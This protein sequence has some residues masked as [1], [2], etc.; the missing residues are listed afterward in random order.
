M[1]LT[2]QHA[3]SSPARLNLP[4]GGGMVDAPVRVLGEAETCKTASVLSED[5]ESKIPGDMG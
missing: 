3:G 2:S 5:L 4:G 1:K